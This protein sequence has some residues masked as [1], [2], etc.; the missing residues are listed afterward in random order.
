MIVF[1]KLN[2]VFS[3]GIGFDFQFSESFLQDSWDVPMSALLSEREFFYCRGA[4]GD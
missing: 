2:S 4:N 3:L 1:F